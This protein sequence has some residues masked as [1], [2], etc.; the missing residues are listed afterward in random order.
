[1]PLPGVAE[2]GAVA[3]PASGLTEDTE[4]GLLDK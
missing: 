3:D 2:Y 4:T 1:M